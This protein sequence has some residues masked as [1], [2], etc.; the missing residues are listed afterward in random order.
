MLQG[1]RAF[2]WGLTIP[3]L[4][5]LVSSNDL[6]LVMKCLTIPHQ[7]SRTASAIQIT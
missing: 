2:L 3:L 6:T 4:L 1:S 7:E 5:M